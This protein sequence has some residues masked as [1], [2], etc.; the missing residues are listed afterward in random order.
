MSDGRA[1]DVNNREIKF[2]FCDSMGLEGDDGMTAADFANIMD[3]HVMDKAPVRDFSS[4]LLSLIVYK[5]LPLFS[6]QTS[7]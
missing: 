6:S 2:R 7:L 1:R 3:G 5:F 4:T